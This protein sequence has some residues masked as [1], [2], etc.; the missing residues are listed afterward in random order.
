MIM[1]S[2]WN[3][4]EFA[5]AECDPADRFIVWTRDGSNEKVQT[6]LF[7]E[8]KEAFINPTTKRPINGVLWWAGQPTINAL[9]FNEGKEL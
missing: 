1:L 7:D 9:A 2:C 8:H 4:Q 3:A 5:P 6:A